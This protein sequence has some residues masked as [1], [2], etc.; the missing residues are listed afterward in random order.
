[1][2]PLPLRSHASKGSVH[3]LG[4]LALATIAAVVFLVLILAD[5]PPAATAPPDDADRP[6]A[7]PAPSTPPPRTTP[8]AP[9]SAS[10]PPTTTLS[11]PVA[12]DDEF[13]AVHDEV[14]AFL[15]G[16]E[17][18]VPDDADAVAED[19]ALR[20]GFEE[21]SREF[22]ALE[23]RLAVIAKSDSPRAA[24]AWTDIAAIRLA[25]AEDLLASPVPARLDEAQAAAYAAALEVKAGDLVD[26]AGEAL[27]MAR[28]GA[29]SPAEQAAIDAVDRRVRSLP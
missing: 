24:A 15:D 14:L 28:A 13:D 16:T 20:R 6:V 5:A 21:R 1:M 22:S 29:R 11:Q 3:L 17:F 23:Q 10:V 4:G 7:P 18:D 9:P 19:Q 27:G 8:T 26:S 2:A 12:R 25:L